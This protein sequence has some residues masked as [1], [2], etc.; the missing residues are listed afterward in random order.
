MGRD[1]TLKE[2]GQTEF[3]HRRNM[4]RKENALSAGNP[5]VKIRI[6]PPK[7]GTVKKRAVKK[8]SGSVWN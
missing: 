3:F 4:R 1:P 7:K 8:V 5:T 2:K 6:K